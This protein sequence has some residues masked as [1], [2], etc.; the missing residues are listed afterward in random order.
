MATGI[1]LGDMSAQC[2]VRI[3][4]NDIETNAAFGV[5][6]WAQDDGNVDESD[7]SDY[8]EPTT[9][10]EVDVIFKYNDVIG[11]GLWGVKN[12]AFDYSA[13]GTL[14]NSG[15]GEGGPLFNAK[16][17]Y[18]NYCDGA[19]PPPRSNSPQ[20]PSCTPGGPSAGP[21]PCAHDL[22]QRNP[23]AKGLG[24]AVDKGTFY[25]PWLASEFET[26][27]YGGTYQGR[28]AYGSDTLMLQPG[29]NT[30]AAPLPLDNSYDTVAEI[31]TLG[32]FL[33]DGDGANLVEQAWQYNHD[34]DS[35]DDLLG[36]A[37]ATVE[38]GRGYFIKIDPMLAPDGTN[39]P[40]IYFKGGIENVA[41]PMPES[42]W[43]LVGAPFGIDDEDDAKAEDDQGRFA[44]A[45]PDYAFAHCF[46]ADE[47]D[48]WMWVEDAFTSIDP[49]IDASGGA[50]IIASP[51]VPG[52]IDGGWAAAWDRVDWEDRM[53]Y[54]GQAYWV[55]M[56]NP[57]ML[58]GFES[59]PL[60]FDV[61]P[62]Q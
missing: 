34:G 18:W 60:Y 26:V 31:E 10:A 24:D 28:R 51:G 16:E 37:P 21:A 13:W 11:N 6:S 5:S 43:Y 38:A 22:D 57:G 50:G 58:G 49:E 62:M 54:A 42:G 35:W 20:Q 55:F 12:W 46:E 25:N 7:T 32:T 23:Y 4:R 47:G 2:G 29:W 8:Y 56:K 40:V 17:N 19:L 59:A 39:F 48:S 1:W 44:V 14:T 41:Y 36:G 53:V 52:Q 30:L 45:D 3:L 61:L 33:L 27:Y 15:S 9:F